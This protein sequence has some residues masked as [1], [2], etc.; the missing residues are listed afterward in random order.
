MVTCQSVPS[1]RQGHIRPTRGQ[2]IVSPAQRVSTPT[3]P[4]PPSVYHVKRDTCVHS[5]AQSSFCV[6]MGRGR[7]LN[8]VLVL[9]VLLGSNVVTERGS[10]A[11]L[12]VMLLLA[13]MSVIH[14]RVKVPT[15]A[16]DLRLLGDAPKGASV[17]LL[18]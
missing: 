1:V 17:L 7:R 2:R 10:N 18:H 11:Q 14:V 6:R 4:V 5:G 12:V 15:V 8:P 3:L 13:P 16:L 9:N